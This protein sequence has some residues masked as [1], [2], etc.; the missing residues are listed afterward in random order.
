MVSE[1]TK[2]RIIE[3]DA[4]IKA[5]EDLKTRCNNPDGI[6]MLIDDMKARKEK[7]IKG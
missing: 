2:D 4:R 6:Q 5:L 7:L 1:N 3:C